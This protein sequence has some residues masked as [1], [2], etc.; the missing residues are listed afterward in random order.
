MCAQFLC[1][2]INFVFKPESNGFMTRFIF[3][4]DCCKEVFRDYESIFCV[5]QNLLRLVNGSTFADVHGI[6]GIRS[7]RAHIVCQK[8]S[9]SF[10]HFFPNAGIEFSS[11][12]LHIG[13]IESL[14]IYIL[15]ADSVFRSNDMSSLEVGDSFAWQTG[16]AKFTYTWLY[17]SR[18]F[19]VNLE[20]IFIPCLAI[21]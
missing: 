4:H 12:R 8:A 18:N 11:L 16:R 1:G 13:H 9:D 21:P 10:F 14:S 19:W 2:R 7:L 3:N 17:V 20:R 6:I 5:A 15:A